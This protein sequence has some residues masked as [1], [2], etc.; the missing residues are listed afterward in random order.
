[1]TYQGGDASDNGKASVIKCVRTVGGGVAVHSAFD[2]SAF[3]S[4]DARACYL[5]AVLNIDF[6]LPHT[7]YGNCTK[8]GVDAPVVG[9][10]LGY[11][12]RAATP[13]P[14]RTV[15]S[16]EFHVPNRTHVLIEIYDVL[17]RKVRTLVDET[18][19]SSHARKWD[20]LDARGE[21][22]S[23]G[24]YFVRMEAGDFRTTRKVVLL[25]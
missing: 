7:A 20:G 17:G 12:L 8:S 19:A 21:R 25:K 4:D 11:D 22:A 3:L 6:G 13:N 1:M 14:F 18:L 24:I 5:D 15:T 9:S 10:R 2:V 23:A 16:I